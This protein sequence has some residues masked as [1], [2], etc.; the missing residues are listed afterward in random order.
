[1][2]FRAIGTGN[3]FAK[4]NWQSNFL[5]TQNGKNLLI[6]CGTYT[7][8]ALAEE[9]DLTTADIDAVYVSH[10]HADHI[11]G[12]EELMFTTYF[13]P[14]LDRPKLFIEGEYHKDPD[15]GIYATGLAA[16]IWNN[17]LSGGGAG[18]EGQVAT[19]DTFFDVRAVK[20]NQSFIW[21]GIIFDI[22]QTIH[23]SSK[24]KLEHSF[25]LMWT[26]PDTNER[27]YL[28]T[29]TQ[30]C[31]VNAMT[32]YLNEADVIFHDC[33]TSP[34]PSGVHAHYNEL[35]ALSDD[36]KAK[37]WLYHYHDNVI[38]DWNNINGKAIEDG[39]LGFVPTYTR[40]D[41]S[42]KEYDLGLVG[43]RSLDQ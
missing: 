22:I 30:F 18:L 6:D 11:G 10:L 40:F 24:Y 34:F 21:E 5:I 4:K 31:P 12:L 16:N 36:I 39:F 42:Y 13:N 17:S 27:V 20:A 19:L 35:V 3:A 41:R 38:E 9:H 26:D 2:H 8:L 43:K 23:I 28:T 29:D 14:T 32:A 33:D 1:M 7:W 15:A 25:G 37:M